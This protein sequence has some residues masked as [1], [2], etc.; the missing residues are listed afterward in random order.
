MSVIALVLG[1]KILSWKKTKLLMNLIPTF[2]LESLK[3]Y[4]RICTAG[5][6]NV[7]LWMF[8]RIYIY[9]SFT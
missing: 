7:K 4:G 2:S 8:F 3:K 9:T 6:Y 1:G 5:V